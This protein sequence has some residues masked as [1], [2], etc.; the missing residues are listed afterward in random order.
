MKVRFL[1]SLFF[2]VSFV[3]A[4]LADGEQTVQTAIK[5]QKF[6]PDEI[7]V[8]ADQPVK[9]QVTN[10]DSIPVEFESSDLNKEKMIPPGKTIDIHLRGL[11][12]GV[13]EFFSDFGPKDLRGKMIVE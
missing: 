8:K 11:P 12:P 13:Y 7:H 2:L 5:H 4:S 3:P 1:L 6:V 9:L 10:E